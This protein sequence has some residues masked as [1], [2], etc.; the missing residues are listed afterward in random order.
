MVL[1][2]Q[3]IMC[4]FSEH[5][6]LKYLLQLLYFLTIT[7]SCLDQEASNFIF[8]SIVKNIAIHV[9]KT[10][11]LFDKAYHNWNMIQNH[12]ERQKQDIHIILHVIFALLRVDIIEIEEM[13]ISLRR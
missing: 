10:S 3:L 13:T 4:E 1:F 5:K 9:M 11:E 7:N 8:R 12:A 2:V 6:E